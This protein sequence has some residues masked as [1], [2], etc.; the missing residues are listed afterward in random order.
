MRSPGSPLRIRIPRVAT[1][2]NTDGWYAVLG[3]L[4]TGQAKLEVWLDRFTG[5]PERKLYAAFHSEDRRKLTSITKRVNRRLWPVREVTMSDIKA[6]KVVKLVQPLQHDEFNLPILE[7]YNGGLTF[8]GVY[9]RTIGSWNRIK[10]GFK[11]EAIA[12]F[13]DVSR[14]LPAA[15]DGDDGANDFPRCENR[16]KVASHLRRERSSTLA[17]ACKDR[18]CYTC[19]CCGFRFAD[20]YGKLGNVFA[21]AHHLT[22]LSKLRENV[23]TRLEDLATVCANCHR[24]LHRMDGERG[25]LQKL[26]ST[27]SRHRR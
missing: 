9:Q 3:D 23:L 19:Q 10:E 7:K 4:G 8:F 2:S 5:Y 6:G 27:V 12:F 14:S 18:D 17:I 13:L 24:M 25:D 26:R 1:K 16:K 15:K 21:E 22:P 11:V 20:Q